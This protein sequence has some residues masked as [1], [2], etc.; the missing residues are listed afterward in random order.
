MTQ[1]LKITFKRFNKPLNF[2]SRLK[3]TAF[4]NKMLEIKVANHLA[5]VKD[6][7]IFLLKLNDSLHN[8]LNKFEKK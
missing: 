7:L 6:L 8:K 5:I 1:F 4:Y 3:M 2:R